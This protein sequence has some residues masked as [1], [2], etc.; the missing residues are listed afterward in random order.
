MPR[1]ILGHTTHNSIKIWLRGS[2]R[3]PAAFVEL[4]DEQDHPVGVIKKVL[5]EAEEFFTSVIELTQLQ[6]NTAYRVKVSFAKTK[7]AKPD[8]RIRDAYTEGRFKTFS[9]PGNGAP[10]RFLFGSCNLHSL[11]LV[12]RPD[13]AWVRI[14]QIA[15]DNNASFMLHCGDQI[16]ADI[17]LSPP[18][19]IDHYRRKYLDAWEDCVPARRA[20]TELPHYMILDDHEITNNFDLQMQAKGRDT[21]AL[22]RIAMKAYWEFQ[23]SHNP[24][25]TGGAYEYHYRFDCGDASFFVM[26]TRYHRDSS[27][28]RML[29]ENQEA[30]LLR[31]IGQNPKKLKFIVSGVPFVGAVLRDGNDKWSHSAFDN[32]RARIL[33]RILD[34]GASNIIFLTGDMHTS[35]H[36]TLDISEGE[37][38]IRIHEL[39]SSPINQITPK[40]KLQ[41]SFH[42]DLESEL[43]GLKIRS[44]I[45]PHSFYGDHSN[46]MVVS[47]AFAGASP[48]VSFEIHRT[49]KNEIGPR[50]VVD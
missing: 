12:A 11:G 32:Q 9:S 22:L 28:G 45:D 15:R 4:L 24:T 50:G 20:L 41:Q 27:I 42:A 29:D 14:S 13:K 43:P 40:T 18:I 31:W 36:A 34:V 46:V 6:A 8:E 26:D 38:T 1:L 5:T 44:T 30:D 48:K 7:S 23:H 19:D 10:F 25:T 37:Q 2:E 35:Y 47:V 3:W 33:K 39:M 49:T 21:D 16:Y 17:P